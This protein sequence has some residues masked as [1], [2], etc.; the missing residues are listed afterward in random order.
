MKAETFEAF[1]LCCEQENSTILAKYQSTRQ[2]EYTYESELELENKFIEIL[3]SQGY[4][5]IELK[6]QKDMEQNL[7]K[8]LE[9][10]NNITFSPNEWKQFFENTLAN[11]NYGIVE[12]TRLIQEQSKQNLKRDDNSNK[13]IDLLNKIDVTK[14]YL[15]VLRQVKNEGS[16][17]N[18]YD[19]SILVNGLPL[20]H[21]ELKRR[22]VSLKEAFN[23]IKR[24]SNESFWAG[25]G[26]FEFI[27]IFVISNGTKTK[28]YSNT[29]RYSKD[30]GLKNSKASANSFEFT[31]N[32]S[33]R[34]NSNISDLTDFAK[35]FFAP[36]TLLNILC[37]FCVFNTES[38][39]LVMRP[40]QISACE[41]IL[42]KIKFAKN[43]NLL[44]SKDAGGY[45]WH[46]TGS[47]KTLT[48]FKV[49]TL[50]KDLVSKV[51]FVVDRKDL[52]YQTIKEYNKFQENAAN[53][54]KDTKELKA[55]LEDDN[56]SIIV[57]TIQ[58]L[59]NFVSKFKNH[60][61]YNKEI[62]IIFD[63]C[64][65]S[66]F[67]KM[68]EAISKSFK[69]YIIFGFTGT[70]IFAQNAN[71]NNIGT[72][73]VKNIFGESAEVAFV[74]N[75]NEMF[76][77]MLHSYTI[78]DAIADKM[79]LPFRVEYINTIKQKDNIEDKE[80]LRI[81]AKEALSDSR[82]IK[83]VVKYIREHFD[84]K[85]KR[86][87][88]YELD[89]KRI[90]GFN[91]IFAVESISFARS[92][93][94]EFKK[95]NKEDSNKLKFGIIYS[96]QQNSDDDSDDGEINESDKD[97]L[98]NAIK[99]YNAIFKSNFSLT[100]FDN[101]YKDISEKLKNRELDL[102]IVVNMFLTGFD[103]KS[104]NTLWVDKNLKE[105]GLLQ[106]FSRTNRI[107][108]TIK[109]FGNI[110]CFRNL[111]DKI[112]E[113]LELFGNKNKD[114]HT[115]LLKDFKSY[116]NK[117]ENLVAELRK[118]FSLE[119]LNNIKKESEKKEFIKLFNEIKNLRNILEAFDE[120][121]EADL[122]TKR[123]MQD[124]TS[125]YIELYDEFRPNNESEKI[126]D[127]IEFEIEL[128][129]QSEINVEYILKLIEDSKKEQR[130][131]LK[132]N[133]SKMIDSTISLR[134]KKKLIIEF[135]EQWAWSENIG[136]DFKNFMKQKRKEEFDEIIKQNNLNEKASYEF[137]NK[138]F[139]VGEFKALGVE[140]LNVL[141]KQSFFSKESG[142]N[143]SK[144]TTILY[145]FF[146]RF[147]DLLEEEI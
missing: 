108:N 38:N 13:N 129:K 112:N 145:N 90:Y 121:E 95:Q 12:K 8:C 102:I 59:N 24:Y 34:E 9:K 80:V 16:A 17:S 22:G 86:N 101:Y 110:I 53:G 44:G 29:T 119:E 62:V 116:L 96:Y 65:R 146:D 49:A 87:Q 93:Y 100:S 30:N 130:E 104:I 35:T 66:Q 32:W 6:T 97:F 58:K 51:L 105:H 120:F 118:K 113:S 82:R 2:K 33:D 43:R 142:E 56:K 88:S 7:K 73:K 99:D 54:S 92:Y 147:A 137:I 63:E 4:E 138:A 52:D 70:P 1:E 26:L 128:I 41:R 3:Q 125:Y 124:Y 18:K 98:E 67:G 117:Y 84:I 74:K 21:I 23:Q 115:I 111:E 11:K 36:R 10:L 81:D 39:L 94:E 28:Y 132:E 40:Y 42:S 136:M 60:D 55:G 85:T 106:A 27:Q 139:K 47:G 75:T 14:N 109:T 19:V 131:E 20:V 123:D 122:L 127:D 114:T 140:F 135:V 37:R 134:S 91:S 31:M 46:S 25:N 15:Q 57:T 76:G 78:V 69:K 61:I 79:V 89:K 107:L 48:S 72:K 103:S 133:I 64:H 83:E 5:Y 144:I 126:N 45:I 71:K 141:P 143:K 77:D 50:A 68:H